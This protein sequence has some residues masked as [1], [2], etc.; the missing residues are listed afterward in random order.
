MVYNF[1]VGLSGG[2]DSVA[3]LHWLHSQGNKLLVTH[4]NF[5]LRGEES[6]RDEAFCRSLCQRMN[7]RLEVM[8][9]DTRSY[10]SEHHV[11]L[12]LA[13]RELRYDWWNRLLSEHTEAKLAIGHHRDDS[14]ETTLFN[15]MRGTGIKGLT[16]IPAEN[17]RIVRPLLSW[18]RND[19]LSYL[20]DNQLDYITDS[21]NLEDE[22]TR[23]KI[24]NQLL[25][26]MEQILPQAR[27]GIEH[28]IELLKQTR[29]LA[30]SQL[31]T[32]FSTAK[33][34]QQD[35][36]IW[37]EFSYTPD[38]GYSKD[39]LFHEWEAKNGTSVCH[40]NLFYTLIEN[41]PYTVPPFITEELS[42]VLP[43]SQNYELFDAD[44]VTLPLTFR[45]WQEGDRIAPLGMHGK[46]RL[47]SDIFS[48]AHLSPMQKAT[49]W[50]VA[51]ANNQIIWVV[52]HKVSETSKVTA[53]TQRTIK[54]TK[55]NR[56]RTQATD[57]LFDH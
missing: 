23:N 29:R 57:F 52:G 17:G 2:P 53:S 5:H 14:I 24:R 38:C 46:Q 11:S 42:G 34:Y 43:F 26:L 13:A 20:Q 3:L 45:H 51:D 28:T 40:D 39:F 41:N 10:M 32:I 56:Q 1:I 27:Q 55:K 47:V 9:F 30:E 7:L 36:V 8:H 48:D 50:I 6:D 49:T 22:A 31:D 33:T 37:K 44:K 19:I 54:I 25:P 16:G 21:S 4:C 35:G 15:L 12:E 18:S